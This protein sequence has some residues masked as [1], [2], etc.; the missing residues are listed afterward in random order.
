MTDI[1]NASSET[2]DSEGYVLPAENAAEMARLMLQDH[3][4][5]RA[6]GGPLPEQTDISELHE[7]LDIGCGPGGGSSTWSCN[8]RICMGWAL[9]LVTS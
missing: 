6:L 9:T 7:A 5:T 1:S 8:I 2:Q 3:M 4:F